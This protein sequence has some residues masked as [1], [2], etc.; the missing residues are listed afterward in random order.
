MTDRE[1]GVGIVGLGHIGQLHI[2]GVQASS[3]ARLAAVADVDPA[4][5]D[6]AVAATGA[7]WY[8]S[9]QD[10]LADPDVGAV[11]VGLPH[12]LHHPVVA[13]VIEAGKDVLVEKPMALTVEECDDLIARAEAAS[14]RLSVDHNQVFDPSHIRARELI[15]D[16]ALGE[17]SFI[18]LRL[19]LSSS[20]PGWRAD[21][22]KVGGGLLFDAGIHRFYLARFLFGDADVAASILDRLSTEGEELAVVVMQFH[23]GAT[24]VIEANYSGSPRSFDD[25]VEITGTVGSIS[26]RGL[27]APTFGRPIPGPSMRWHD[28]ERWY[29]EDYAVSA[30][31]DYVASVIKSIAAFCDAMATPSESPPV[32]GWDGRETIRLVREAYERATIIGPNPSRK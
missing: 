19:G 15:A 9:V 12:H 17:P 6:E 20:H 14:V 21:V 24:G 26:I 2:C 22:A 11:T 16:G 8:G 10:L 5:V 29:D 3:K 13:E 18:R 31:D 1:L 4:L 30:D 25:S 23:N 28:G 32:T 27:E 7:R